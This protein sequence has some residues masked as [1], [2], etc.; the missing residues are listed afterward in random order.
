MAGLP[1]S[2]LG[3]NIKSDI[4]AP[5]NNPKYIILRSLQISENIQTKISSALK[6]GKLRPYILYC[7]VHF[8][9][10]P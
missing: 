9:F 6:A 5:K 1:K 10:T 7:A 3:I 8:H 2:G 4:K